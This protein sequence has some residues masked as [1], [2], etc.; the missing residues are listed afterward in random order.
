MAGAADI[1]CRG[2]NPTLGNIQS[3]KRLICSDHGA[4]SSLLDQTAGL[5]PASAGK[6]QHGFVR[7]V[8]QSGGERESHKVA[9]VGETVG[10]IVAHQVALVPAEILMD[11]VTGCGF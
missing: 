6:I 10:E 2:R 8:R 11:K 5:V 1:L 3:K 7:L 4:A 9:P